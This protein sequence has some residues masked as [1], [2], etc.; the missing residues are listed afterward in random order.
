MG[1]EVELHARSLSVIF[2][3]AELTRIRSAIRMERFKNRVIARDRRDRKGAIQIPPRR[4]GGTE[5]SVES[6][7][8]TQHLETTEKV[9]NK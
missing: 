3:E 7:N 1:P 5:Q 4:H 9:W 2:P 8:Q 6:K